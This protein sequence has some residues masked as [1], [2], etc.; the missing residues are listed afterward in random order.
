MGGSQGML[1]QAELGEEQGGV[2]ASGMQQTCRGRSMRL[3]G[4]AQL[5]QR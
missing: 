2:L 3:A 4:K 5:L 1:C